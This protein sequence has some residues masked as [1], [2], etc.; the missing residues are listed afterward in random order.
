MRQ[1]W[2]LAVRSDLDA[3]AFPS[4][5][6]LLGFLMNNCCSLPVRPT[7]V[8]VEI[9]GIAISATLDGYATFAK[10]D[11]TITPIPE[12]KTVLLLSLGLSVLGFAKRS[13]AALLLGAQKK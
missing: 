2:F 13:P 10:G 12:P 5:S 8:D 7:F 9:E 6:E 3:L 1:P 4:S 11:V